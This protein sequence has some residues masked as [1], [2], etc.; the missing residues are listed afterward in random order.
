MLYSVGTLKYDKGNRLVLNTSIG[1]ADF[2]RSLIP[3]HIE[4][5]RPRYKPH[6]TVV[7]GKY[8][9]PW[10]MEFWGKY[11]GEKI[12]Y[13]YEPYVYIDHTYIWLK[14]NCKRLEEIR[15]ELG[16]NRCRDKF[17][18]FHITIGNTKNI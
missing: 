4:F 12:T 6:A 13:E 14:V 17:K 9:D 2:Y 7:R 10:M 8:E 5:N 16:L 3:K 1:M 15:L 11:E 18:W